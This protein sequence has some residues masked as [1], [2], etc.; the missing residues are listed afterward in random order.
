[1]NTITNLPRT[2]SEAG[3][4]EVKLKRKFSYKVYHRNEYI[5]TDN[6]FKALQI[7]KENGHPDYQNFDDLSLYEKRCKESDPSGYGMVFEDSDDEIDNDEFTNLIKNKGVNNQ[8]LYDKQCKETNQSGYKMFEDCDDEIDTDEIKKCEV[9][10]LDD[11]DIECIRDLEDLDDDEVDELDYLKNDPI[12]KFQFA[13]DK[14][15]CLVDS[16][17]E[18]AHKEDNKS[19]SNKEISFAPGEGKV[20]TNILYED[21]WEVKSFP[22]LFPNGKNHLHDK[23]S[24]KLTDQQ[25][26]DQRIRNSDSRFVDNTG[27][28]YAAAAYLEKK[29]LQRN[30]D[31]SYRRGT[32]TTNKKGE[33]T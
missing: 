26:F 21:N 14:S 15:V 11:I 8:N 16:H 27:Y 12:R 25:Y 22:M 31:I 24:T 30:I 1:M 28:V 29:Q 18:A 5:N 33:K 6:I 13:Y 32:Q 2:P 17:P 4:V 19:Y 10:F 3:L 9:N 7:L 23:R 20:P